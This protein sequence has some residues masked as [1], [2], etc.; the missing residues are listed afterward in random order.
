MLHRRVNGYDM[1][2]IALG[3]GP[4]LVCVH[5]TLCDFRVWSCVLG[6]L[7]RRHRV[8]ALSLRHFFP[9]H[10]DGVGSDYTMAQHVADVIGF[11]E[12]LGEG[13]VDLMGH[14]RGGHIAFRV[15]QQ[16]PDLLRRLVL[17]EPGGDLDA[18]LAPPG[19][20]P[21]PMRAPAVAAAAKIAA[22]DVDGGLAGFIDA[23]T[24]R[25]P[26]VSCRPREA[27]TARQREHAAGAGQRAAPAVHARR[28]RGDRGADA[29]RGGRGHARVAAGGAAGAGGA[30]AGRTGRDDRERQT[31]HVRAGPDAVLRGG[32]GVP[33][34][35]GSE[36]GGFCCPVPPEP[37]L[38]LMQR[39]RAPLCCHWHLSYGPITAEPC[40]AKDTSLPRVSSL[41]RPHVW[42]FCQD[43]GGA[44][45]CP[46]VHYAYSTHRLSP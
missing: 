34:G 46:R 7:S 15:A 39:Q 18:S 6:P 33:G 2:F 11:I 31:L 5:G 17:A 16:R 29:V 37:R 23:V 40:R 38:S 8:V 10:W 36:V 14:S 13:S 20:A 43:G 22:G 4:P 25:A 41:C 28:C 19:T 45:H 9:E 21:P 42:R 3:E 44:G 35:I 24:A 32:D 30:C 12:A 26:G 1:A 27:G